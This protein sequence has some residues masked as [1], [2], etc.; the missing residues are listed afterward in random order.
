MRISMRERLCV[1]SVYAFVFVD[2]QTGR[3]HSHDIFLY[4]FLRSRL[5]SRSFKIPTVK[6]SNMKI[7]Y[8]A[9]ENITTHLIQMASFGVAQKVFKM[10][11][12]L[13]EFVDC[14]WNYGSRDL[15]RNFGA[16]SWKSTVDK[17]KWMEFGLFSFLRTEESV[18]CWRSTG[19]QLSLSYQRTFDVS[20]RR[21]AHE[22]YIEEENNLT[23]RRNG[24]NH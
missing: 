24:N 14:N 16:E 18:W 22:T 20:T 11:S 23:D 1:D 8:L 12:N 21:T 5:K 17:I 7:P 13:I 6:I 15:A 9:L 10:I 3:A 4:L 19:A 2:H